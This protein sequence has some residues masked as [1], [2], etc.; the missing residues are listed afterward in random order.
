MQGGRS[1][2]VA[3]ALCVAFVE[4][5]KNVTTALD[6]L[7]D[8]LG[9]FAVRAEFRLFFE[10]KNE[11]GAGERNGGEGRAEFVSDACGEGGKCGELSIFFSLDASLFEFGVLLDED[12]VHARDKGSNEDGGDNEGVKHTLQVPRVAGTAA[13]NFH[14]AHEQR[15]VPKKDQGVAYD[16]RCDERPQGAPRHCHG[17]QGNVQEV[18]GGEGVMTAA[19]KIDES[20]E[21]EHI[22]PKRCAGDGDV[23]FAQEEQ[24][25]DNRY[26]DDDQNGGPWH[27][28]VIGALPYDGAENLADR[29][30]P[31]HAQDPL[32]T[33]DFSFLEQFSS[34][35]VDA[36]VAMPL[37]QGE[38]SSEFCGKLPQ[39]NRCSE[40]QRVR[41]LIEV[42]RMKSGIISKLRCWRRL[43]LASCSSCFA[44]RLLKLVGSM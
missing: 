26:S 16:G 36:V 24:V 3:E 35:G 21:K 29:S 2:K 18:E 22:E 27:N 8:E 13:G 14:I 38:K 42:P 33:D 28:E 25:G 30:H 15:L 37:R 43:P 12:A 44:R 1:R 19:C 11:L 39:V 32:G 5:I 31:A 10:G 41:E 4:S 20:S 40:T 6:L 34:H 17:C 9:I 7:G 23:W